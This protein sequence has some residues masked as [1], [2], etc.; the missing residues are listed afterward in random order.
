MKA[1]QGLHFSVWMSYDI[2]QNKLF[3]YQLSALVYSLWQ[4][5]SRRADK[6]LWQEGSA[7]TIS[8]VQSVEKNSPYNIKLTNVKIRF[9]I[10]LAKINSVVI[11]KHQK[12]ALKKRICFGTERWKMASAGSGW[13]CPVLKWLNIINA[14]TNIPDGSQPPIPCITAHGA[15]IWCSVCQQKCRKQ[16]SA[17]CCSLQSHQVLRHVA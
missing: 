15:P 16:S 2:L 8:A 3:V 6:Q 10:G 7:L 12:K 17:C 14:T 13:N 4:W 11:N 9:F 1:R 5:V